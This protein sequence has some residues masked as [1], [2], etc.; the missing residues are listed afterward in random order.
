MGVTPLSLACQLGRPPCGTGRL[1]F[2]S[3]SNPRALTMP[4]RSLPSMRPR[5]AHIHTWGCRLNSASPPYRQTLEA[6]DGD[7]EMSDS[8]SDGRGGQFDAREQRFVMLWRRG[9]I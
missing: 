5:Y 9:C 3:A 8:G 1:R 4:H 7:G 2:P 6:G